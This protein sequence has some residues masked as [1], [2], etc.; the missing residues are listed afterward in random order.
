MQCIICVC[1]FHNYTFFI[2]LNV[3]VIIT[4]LFCFYLFIFHF[5]HHL[6]P[7]QDRNLL[8]VVILLHLL[9]IYCYS[10][11]C[12][13]IIVLVYHSFGINV[14]SKFSINL[15]I[16]LRR[17]YLSSHDYGLCC[18]SVYCMYSLDVLL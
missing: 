5:C 2:H 4:I 18:F 1:F 3:F 16:C 8:L 10:L 7:V 9:D 12:I 6:S 17:F 13:T 11:L 14:Y 15:F